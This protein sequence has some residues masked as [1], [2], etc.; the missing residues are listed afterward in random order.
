MLNEANLQE[1]LDFRSPHP[2]LSV[3]VNT[4]PT[5]GNADSY[6]LEL[7]NLLKNVSLTEDASAVERYFEHSYDWSGRSVAVFSCVPE[8]FLRAY[9]LAVAVQSRVRINTSP[10]VKPLVN[11]LNFYGG[12]GVA[13]VDKQGARLFYF[14][15][16]ELREQEGVL[17]ES[18]RHSKRDGVFDRT[19]HQD[20][21]VEHNMKDAVDF[22]NRF[23]TE[24]TVRR[25]V[26]CGSD[27]NVSQFRSH[28]PKAWQSLVVG[29]FPMSMTASKEEVLA[30]T[31]EV[32]RL[33]EYRFEENLVQSVITSTAKK[34]GAVM[35]LDS[36]LKAVHDGRVH[37]LVVREG[38]RSP[39]YLCQGCG[40]ITAH[41]LPTCPFC[42]NTFNQIPDAIE[43]AIRTVIKQGGEIEML[44]SP[45]AVER[46]GDIGAVLRY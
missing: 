14:H 23:F 35:H 17:G 13:L 21:L 10:H 6:K 7:R 3:Y 8:N 20:E 26:I 42:S 15:L 41:P 40:Y 19:R 24:N 29:S 32:G 2:V 9:P 46:L 30:R 31:M 18:V 36:T 37:T 25:L 4:D 1:L 33:A 22:A 12:Y 39:G 5:I 34:N 28:L 16:G 11:L 43:M 45:A 38:L 27:D 44:Q